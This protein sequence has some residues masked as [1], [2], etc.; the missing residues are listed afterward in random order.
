MEID[1]E[2]L[3]PVLNRM[4]PVQGQPARP[5]D[6]LPSWSSVLAVVAHPDDES[7]GLGA[8][9]DKFA[10][11]GSAVSVLCLTQ[12]EASTLHG[13]SADLA[14]LRA[15]EMRGAARTLGVSSVV[16]RDY[17]DG[18][19]STISPR[20]LQAEVAEEIE[21]RGARGV[22]VF[23]PSGV[24][25]HP[26][27]GAAS[28]AGLAAAATLDLP[29]LAWTIPRSVAQQLN[30]E[31]DAGFV[32]HGP[33][34][35]DLTIYVDRDRQRSASLV[36]ASQAIPTSVLWRR[37][38]LLGNAEHLRWLRRPDTRARTDGQGDTAAA[39]APTNWAG[40]RVDYRSGDRF[41]IAIRD[42]LVT[43]DQ[44]L[45]LGGDDLGPTPTELFVAGLATCVAFYAR[46]YLRRHK[47]DANGLAVEASYRLGSAPARVSDIDIC[48][49][50]PFELPPARRDG[51]LAV[52][53][54]CT[55]HNSITHPPRIDI[56]LAN[57]D[58][59]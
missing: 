14:P 47:L 35:I 19:L 56:T 1:A 20:T 5:T 15:A 48:V 10:A 8:I 50:L 29:V 32:G 11:A 45:D 46:R 44:P 7:F 21:Q 57:Q 58:C 9:L 37:L 24:S 6:V 16:L 13:V 23:D 12:G 26:D 34:A 55:V 31:F 54:H 53:G 17:P 27:H 30:E 49:H 59:R 3:T 33:A 4:P 18:H 2:Q 40:M 38:E 25:G 43:V 28:A 41:D 39:S 36:H 51:L 52:A 22:I 42:H